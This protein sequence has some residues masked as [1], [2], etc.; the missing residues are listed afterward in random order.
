MVG[1]AAGLTVMTLVTGAS[2][3]PQAS[4]A[5]HVSV[6]VP[7]QAPA[8]DCAVK[9]DG[10]DV[11]LTRQLPVKPLLKLIVL[12]AG[13]A[14]QATVT[15]A[16]AVMVGSAAGLTVMTLVTGASTLPQASVAVHVSVMVP[17]QAPEGNCAEKVDGA[18][19]PLIRQLPVKPLE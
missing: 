5:V 4:V 10:A 19:V 16:G 2:T 7:P 12:A 17:P 9:V 11:P 14:P 15:A 13:T 18:D 1:S 3:L 6:M 8:G